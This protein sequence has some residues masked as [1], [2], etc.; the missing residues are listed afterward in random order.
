MKYLREIIIAFSIAIIVIMTAVK[1]PATSVVLVRKNVI[2]LTRQEKLDFVNAVKTLKTQPGTNNKNVSVYDEFVSIHMGAMSFTTMHLGGLITLP[3]DT[4]PIGLAAGTDAAHEN[5]G[6]L[7]WHREYLSRLEKALQSV[8]P[9]VTIPYWD[10]ADP[11]SVDVIFAPDFLGSNGSG[12]V[13]DLPNGDKLEGGRVESGNF[14]EANGWSLIP[15]L[16]LK[17]DT[18]ETLGT[19]LIRY[20]PPQSA[21]GVLGFPLDKEQT[22]RILQSKDYKT[23]QLFVEGQ[24]VIDA[25]GVE[26]RCDRE[27]C[28]HNLVHGLLDGS[29]QNPISPGPSLRSTL[30]NVP[31]SPNDPVFWLLHANV[32]RLWAEWQNNGRQGSKFYAIPGTELYGHNLKDKMWPWDGGDSI[33]GSV[34]SIDIRPYLPVIASDDIVRPKDTLSLRKYGYTYDT[35]VK[36]AFKTFK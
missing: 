13:L 26:K 31:A 5:G 12:D 8:N 22:D 14:S 10:W 18:A 29:L 16:H 32:D 35:L 2:N 28:N 23:F 36:K 4:P 25:N 7:P 30:N 34:G 1:T 27:P 11:R 33:P 24:I 9:K 6:F 19:S 15:E 3:Q 17:I 21:P 20:L